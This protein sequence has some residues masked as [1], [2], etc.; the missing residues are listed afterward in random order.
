MYCVLFIFAYLF[1]SVPTASARHMHIRSRT[2]YDRHYNDNADAVSHQIRELGYKLG[3]EALRKYYDKA[4]GCGE[5]ILLFSHGSLH[6][7]SL[8][9][10]HVQIYAYS[11]LMRSAKALASQ[12]I[13]IDS[14]EPLI[15][16]FDLS[17]K[18]SCADPH[19]AFAF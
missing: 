14:P 9:I 10:A 2:T 7:I 8:F 11:L 6:E 17:S 12:C 19:F 16:T 4:S 15:L 5:Y 1:V 18:F 13:C 3:A